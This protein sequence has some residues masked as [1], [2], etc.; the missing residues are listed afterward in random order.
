MTVTSLRPLFPSVYLPSLVFETGIG[1]AIPMV[2]VRAGELGAS[3]A[4]A[5]FLTAL[6]PL[7]KILADVPAGALA[8]RIGDRRTMI[9][10]SVV[11]VGAGL[12]AALANSV[13]LFAAGVLVVGMTDAVYQLARQS[14][15]AGA[16]HPLR[17]ARALS[18][19]GGVHRVGLFA[20]PFLTAGLAPAFGGAGGF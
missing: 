13:V 5:G 11:A 17:R 4:L 6:L 10:A 18:T 16:V 19:L 8:A 20:G 1:A 12:T 14:Y 2:V 15:V 3:L 7:G 9:L